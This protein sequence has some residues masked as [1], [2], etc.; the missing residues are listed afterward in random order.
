MHTQ[1]YLLIYF[2]IHIFTVINIIHRSLDKAFLC[3]LVPCQDLGNTP[4]RLHIHIYSYST[5]ISF[6]MY[7]LCLFTGSLKLSV[8]NGTLAHK[9]KFK[10]ISQTTFPNN[11]FVSKYVKISQEDSVFGFVVTL[12]KIFH[13][14]LLWNAK[15]ST[16]IF[17]Y[18][19]SHF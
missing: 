8:A 4:H 9:F 6:H 18:Q 14:L 5:N 10:M 2:V 19:S 11:T 12:E 1:H 15:V 17:S 7:I 16:E 13:Y 3:P